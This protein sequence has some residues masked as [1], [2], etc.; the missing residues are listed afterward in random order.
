MN[1]TAS[2]RINRLDL[3]YLK[4]NYP[5]LTLLFIALVCLLVGVLSVG[6]P[7]V[8]SATAEDFSSYLSIRQN[9]TFI[10]S[11]VFALICISKYPVVSFLCGTSVLGLVISPISLGLASYRYGLIA[12][13]IYTEYGLNG[14]V[15]NLFALL[16]PS[17]VYLF[18]LLLMSR[19]CIGFSRLVAS[20]CVKGTRP[21]NLF[22]P[23]KLYCIHSLFLFLIVLL[24]TFIDIT[25]FGLFENY[26]SF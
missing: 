3:G 4:E 5:F 13:F 21:V 15:F 1:R 9:N 12:G 2:I 7:D 8:Y 16:L 22:E 23:F 26:F 19:E 25:L 11:F 17:L 6:N 24:S 14:I 20:M 10:M 18:G